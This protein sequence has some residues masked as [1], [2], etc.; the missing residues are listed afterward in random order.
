[1]PLNLSPE[2]AGLV[3]VF[4]GQPLT[5]EGQ[6]VLTA[7]AKNRKGVLANPTVTFPTV[8]AKKGGKAKVAA[9]PKPKKAKK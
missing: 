1:M 2:S 8:T 7:N 6:R 3:K 9:K 5:K 4:P